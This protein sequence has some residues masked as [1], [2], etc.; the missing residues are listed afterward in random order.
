MRALVTGANGSLGAW[1]TRKIVRFA[2]QVRCLVPK[3]IAT[4]ELEGLPIQ[5]MYGDVV[6]P[7]RSP[8]PRRPGRS[9]WWTS[10]TWWIS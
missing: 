3:T 5:L 4:A 2:A 8:S 1:L 10:M 9:R 7:G 6:D